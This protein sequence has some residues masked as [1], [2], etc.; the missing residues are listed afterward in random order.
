MP[1]RQFSKN[2]VVDRALAHSVRDGM[3][4]SVMAGGGETYLSAF[5]LFLRAT[6]PQVAL[7]STLPPLLG[8]LA[9]VFSAWLGTFTSR[10]RIVLAGC[11]LQALLWIPILLVPVLVESNTV[12][13]LLVL[14]CLY[15]SANHFAAPQWTSLMRDLVS[16]RRRGRYFGHRTRLTTITT[17]V[18]LVLCG[19]I[20]HGFDTADRTYLG[21]AIIFSIAF[22]ARSVSVYHL[23]FMHEPPPGPD[24]VPDMHIEQWWRGLQTTGSLGFSAYVALMNG[25]VGISSPFF[26]VYMLRDLGLS[27]FEFTLLSGTSVFVQFLSLRT[28]GRVADVYGNRLI[29]M[30]TSM[31]LPV[32]PLLWLVSDDFWYL[33]AIQG[34]SGLSWSGFTLC[35]GNLLYEIVPTTRRAAYVAFHNVGAAAAVF[36]GAMLGA[37]LVT[38]MPPRAVLFGSAAVV[39][40]LLYVFA[41][42]GGARAIIAT[43]LARRI[44]D[45]RKPRKALSA[46]AFVM[47]VIGLNTMLELIYD[48]TRATQEERADEGKKKAGPPAD[49]G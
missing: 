23:T 16:E 35:A 48:L 4:Y 10:K 41:F 14:F 39:S 6:A 27:Y 21:F 29:L 31:A 26:A 20:L 36:V 18:A 12:I 5:A 1:P 17:F 47:R 34:L 2:P 25:A 30:V 42:S 44:R 38:F 11:T 3:A 37:A 22:L 19:L 13:A 8:S 49:P 33:M 46:H 32:I 24:S 28:W 15:F 45:I 40:N 9:Q 43:L 7:L